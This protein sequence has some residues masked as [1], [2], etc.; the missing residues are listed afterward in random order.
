MLG[1]SVGVSRGGVPCG[2]RCGGCLWEGLPIVQQVKVGRS[3]SR[4]PGRQVGRWALWIHDLYDL[5]EKL[6]FYGVAQGLG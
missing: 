2:G 3:S 6:H 5:H 4:G 1:G